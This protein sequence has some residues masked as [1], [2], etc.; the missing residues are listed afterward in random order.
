M[1][2]CRPVKMRR[3]RG[4]KWGASALWKE[5]LKSKRNKW[6]TLQK[7]ASRAKVSQMQFRLLPFSARYYSLTNRRHCSA[8]L[9]M[10]AERRARARR[11]QA[12]FEAN[13]IVCSPLLCRIIRL[14]HR[15]LLLLIKVPNQMEVIRRQI[16]PAPNCNGELYRRLCHYCF[17]NCKRCRCSSWQ[18]SL[19]IPNNRAR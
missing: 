19:S 13:S 5:M 10:Q 6:L 15:H 18:T 8:A 4:G 9:Q 1:C 7:N 3:C 11:L 2:W 17:L 14:E 16:P 12:D